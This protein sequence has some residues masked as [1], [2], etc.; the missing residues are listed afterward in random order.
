MTAALLRHVQSRLVATQAEVFFCL[1]RQRLQQLILVVAG[2][3]IVAGQAV[4]HRG[5]MHR[6]LDVGRLLVRMAG[7]AERRPDVA[8]ISLTR[9][10]SLLTRTSWQLRQP[11]AMAE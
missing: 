1:A 9:V 5:R 11:V 6:P 10:M 2:V 3:R 7:E 4:A 8:V